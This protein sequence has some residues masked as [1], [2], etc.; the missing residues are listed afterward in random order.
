MKVKLTRIHTTGHLNFT[1][2][3]LT[4]RWR[5]KIE[6]A[7]VLYTTTFSYLATRNASSTASD[8]TLKAARNHYC[9]FHAEK[10]REFTAS[11]NPAFTFPASSLIHF[12]SDKHGRPRAPLYK[13]AMLSFALFF[14]HDSRHT[15]PRRSTATRRRPFVQNDPIKLFRP[16]RTAQKASPS[17]KTK[18]KEQSKGG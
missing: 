10:Q 16:S 9:R 4:P 15:F 18:Q 17:G 5:Q 8:T 11:W 3:H 1:N 12:Y 13:S 2:E 14:P 6:A 7:L